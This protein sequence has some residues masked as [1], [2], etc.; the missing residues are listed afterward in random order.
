ML[1]EDSGIEVDALGGEPGVASA[2]WAEAGRQHEAL[3]ERLGGEPNRA[4][5]MICHMVAI[6]PG[7]EEVDAVGVL[8]G[9]IA[10]ESRGTEGFGYDPVFVAEGET[11]TN[12]ELGNAWKRAHSHRA[13]AAVALRAALDAS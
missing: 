5:R 9:E 8:D 12:A 13:R 6:G 4:A 7:G 10:R 3:L 1:G 2:R 11:R